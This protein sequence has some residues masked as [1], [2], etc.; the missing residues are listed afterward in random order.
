[1]KLIPFITRVLCCWLLPF[2]C[3]SQTQKF[4][5][6][7]DGLSNSLINQIYQDRK[8]FIW[9]ATEWGLNKYDSNKFRI[10]NH[11]FDN[12][13]SLT[14]NYVRT[15][16][17]DS[18]GR[19]FVGL[20]N[21]LMR[22]DPLSDSFVEVKVYG[23]K[24]L[25]VHP[26]VTSIVELENGDLIFATSG[27]GLFVLAKGQSS[28]RYFSSLSERLSN[29][30]ISVFQ[31]KSKNLW[32]ASETGGLYLYDVAVNKLSLF[33]AAN[34]LMGDNVSSVVEDNSGNVFIGTLTN[35]LF[36]YNKKKK[37]ILSAGNQGG[38]LI[39]C[40]YVSKSADLLIG[41][42]GQ[43]VKIYDY[44][45]NQIKD[46]SL[47]TFPYDI[48]QGKVHSIIE[49]KEHNFWLGLFQKGVVFISSAPNRFDYW[50]LKQNI[51]NPIGVGSVISICKD[52]EGV[53]WIGVDNEGLYGVD[54]KGQGVAHFKQ[55]A[56][57]SSVSNII[58]SVFEDRN[59]NLWLGS[60]TSGLCRMNKQTGECLYIP[61]LKGKPV[62]FITEDNLGNL[63]VATYGSGFFR[64]D[65]QT[66]KIEQYVSS[67]KE[68]DDYHINEL[69]NDWINTLMCD[70]AGMIWIGHHKGLSCYDPQKKT[71]I[72]YLGKNN[73]LPDRVVVSLMEARDGKIW[74]GT[75]DGLVSFD[76]KNARFE[77]FTTRNN[78]SNNLVCAMKQDEAGDIWI[79]TYHGLS[80][81]VSSKKQFVNYYVDDGIQGYEFT[82]GA[83]CKDK[84]GIMYFGGTNGLT[85]FDPASITSERRTL[86]LLL[87]DF[88]IGNR[89]I[90][91]K[92]EK[93]GEQFADKAIN[94]ASS[95]SLSDKD[96]SFSIEF[97]SMDYTNSERVVYQYKLEGWN[98]EWMSTSPGINR[99]SFTNLPSGKY[100]LRVKVVDNNAVSPEK[101]FIIKIRTPWYASWWAYSIY[102]L[103]LFL[104][105]GGIYK[106]YLDKMHYKEELEEQER[107][108]A[109][110]ESKLQ[111]FINISHEIRTPMSLIISPLEK[112]MTT[113]KD[114]EVHKSYLIIQRNA[115]RILRLINQL[116]DVR[117]L[118]KGQMHIKCRRTDI[119]GFIKDL[120]LTFDYQAKKKDIEFNFKYL[121]EPLYVWIDLNNFDKVLLN[122]FSNAFKF[123]P[124]GGKIDVDLS[125]GHDPDAEYPLDNY[126]Q[127]VI[128]DTGIGISMEHIEKIFD[129]FYQ[130]YSPEQSVTVGTGVGL[131]LARQLVN[132]HSGIIYA[133]NRTDVQGSRFVVRLPFGY[134]H[135]KK[136]QVEERALSEMHQSHREKLLEVGNFVDEREEVE[137]HKPV[138]SKTNYTILIVEDD[139]EIR[140]Y[141]NSELSSIYK[142]MECSNGRDGYEML[143]AKQPDLVI[144]DI[145]MPEMDGITL[146][147]K[148]KQNVNINHIPVILL[149]AKSASEDRHEGLDIG[150]DAYVL[151]PFHI[152]DLIHQINNI[153][154]NRA[155][156]KVKYTG[157]QDHKDMLP[158]IQLKSS[159]EILLEKVMKII[160]AN[161]AN[162]DLNVEML[163]SGVGMSRVHMHRKLKELMSTSARDLIRSV[164]LRQAGALL[165]SKKLAV[166]E[167]AYATGFSNLSYFSNA[168]REF[169]GISPTDYVA[170]HADDKIK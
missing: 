164:R 9:I 81:F 94:E 163:A 69:A 121:E 144:S 107:A 110:N 160:N 70:K 157:L 14:N 49:D 104:F 108:Q 21:G 156:L 148:V 124:D 123:T 158:D 56:S 95:F 122:L 38:V 68:N 83:S 115:N 47:R 36:I 135:L 137:K 101:T 149:T 18:K 168:F 12:P 54:Q 39:K 2:V 13:S 103:L 96:N 116:M 35:G 8:G 165:K 98:S 57:P 118:D 24:N 146:C 161:I 4:Y 147:R 138:K 77:K 58:L 59:G 140:G 84:E 125:V 50:G 159:D 55:T 151:K 162:P 82:R 86:R 150:A 5:T 62:F 43:G 34:P 51:N 170:S 166:S 117:K 153:I 127:V 92:D 155:L 88:Y 44:A 105:L 142:I 10:Y 93:T 131:H 11:A 169:Y 25:V 66:G 63:L 114:S 139:E 22:Y 79:S 85:F 71:Y 141:L 28:A 111:Y 76:K 132:L 61:Q 73:I 133:E 112:L 100:K 152:D 40:L 65:P 3:L 48:T 89:R 17:E 75:T 7:D 154:R 42:D 78:L 16:F 1:M 31:D 130:V 64:F 119:V 129:R 91:M 106:Y 109:A 29:K 60:F 167:V 45:D 97:S 33:S 23:E 32:I 37:T 27:K 74:V 143:L 67:K 126:F 72:N 20:I 87:T 41:T 99:I 145:M 19:F 102:T 113:N 6:T 52:R 128:S 30:F 46:Y 15:M 120:M 80:K 26:H 90:G 134:T 136:E 53:A